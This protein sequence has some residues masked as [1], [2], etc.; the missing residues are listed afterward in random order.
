M[1]YEYVCVTGHTSCSVCYTPIG[2]QV[3]LT[4]S[5]KIDP[6]DSITYHRNHETNTVKL[7]TAINS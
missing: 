5:D 4:N 6:I 3:R 2:A 1:A 7:S